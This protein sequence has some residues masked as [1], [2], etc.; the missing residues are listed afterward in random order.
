MAGMVA[1]VLNLLIVTHFCVPVTVVVGSQKRMMYVAIP[2]HVALKEAICNR[3]THTRQD[4][5]S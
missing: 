3:L 4:L 2:E 1:S 5:P